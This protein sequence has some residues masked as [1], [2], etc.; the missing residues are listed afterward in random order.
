M[1]SGG[2]YIQMFNIHGRPKNFWN[3]QVI[4]PTTLFVRNSHI[5]T[6]IEELQ[7]EML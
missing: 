1:I 5:W 4:S 2:D 3:H 6:L 7:K